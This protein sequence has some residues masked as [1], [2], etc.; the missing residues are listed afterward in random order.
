MLRTIYIQQDG[1]KNHIREDDE[2]FNNTLME[3]DIDAKLYTETSNSPG[4]NLFDLGSSGPF[5]ASTMHRRRTK[6]S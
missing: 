3:Q 4:T 6:K 2:E 5:R 1:P